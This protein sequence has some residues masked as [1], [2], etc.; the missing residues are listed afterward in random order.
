[1]SSVYGNKR[2]A[3]SIIVLGSAKAVDLLLGKFWF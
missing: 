1:M 3:M 2:A